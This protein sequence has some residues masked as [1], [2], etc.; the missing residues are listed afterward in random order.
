MVGLLFVGRF[1]DLVVGGIE[2]LP[3]QNDLVR[4]KVPLSDLDL[5]HGAPGDVAATELQTGGQGVLGHASGFSDFSNI[6]SDSVLDFLIHNI[7]ILHLYWN[8]HS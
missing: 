5:G 2:D 4:V 3:E 7:T 6:L 1:E 8:N